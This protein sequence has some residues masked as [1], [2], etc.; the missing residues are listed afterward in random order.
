[1]KNTGRWINLFLSGN[2][3]F[4]FRSVKLEMHMRYIGGIVNWLCSLYR[5]L[6]VKSEP[7]II[8]GH[9]TIFRYYLKLKNGW[10]HLERVWEKSVDKDWGLEGRIMGVG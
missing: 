2:Q 4:S 9:L 8:W 5:N 7:E 6:E 10:G 3:D 1:M